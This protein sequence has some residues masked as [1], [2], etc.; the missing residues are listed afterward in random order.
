MAS[1]YSREYFLSFFYPIPHSFVQQIIPLK[2]KIKI[3]SSPSSYLALF[4]IFLLLE[5]L[6]STYTLASGC[7]KEKNYLCKTR[8][9]I[10]TYYIVIVLTSSRSRI[11]TFRK[12]HRTLHYSLLET[13]FALES[14]NIIHTNIN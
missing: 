1:S 5:I 3:C 2:S 10:K 4:H 14:I 12:V 13:S 6:H 8:K 11:V 7:C 9:T